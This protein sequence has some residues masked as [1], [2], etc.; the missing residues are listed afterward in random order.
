MSQ[1]NEA[2]ATLKVVVVSAK[3]KQTIAVAL[4]S[5]RPHPLYGKYVKHTTRLLAHDEEG[6][7]REGDVVEIVQTR[8][9]SRRKSWKLVRVLNS[10]E[11]S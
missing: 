8:P 2:R 6:V 11:Q 7:A 5:T 10:T 4:V 1:N 9:I 3:A